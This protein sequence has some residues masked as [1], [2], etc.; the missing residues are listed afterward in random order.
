VERRGWSVTRGRTRGNPRL[1]AG[2]ENV[3]ICVTW[4]KVELY[5]WASHHGDESKNYTTT[6]STTSLA[7][8][9]NLAPPPKILLA[10][11]HSASKSVHLFSIPPPSLPSHLTG[12]PL[13]HLAQPAHFKDPKIT[14]L[15]QVLRA[16]GRHSSSGV[17][18]VRKIFRPA[19]KRPSAFFSS[20]QANQQAV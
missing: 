10:R 16:H 17:Q 2:I 13:F 4:T 14:P 20:Y 6:M 3:S 9:R 1:Q 12:T 7:I 5:Q 18:A 15:G 8:V 19:L 11:L